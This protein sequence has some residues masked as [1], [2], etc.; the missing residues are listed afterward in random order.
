MVTEVMIT[1]TAVVMGLWC[2]NDGSGLMVV[3]TRALVT[4]VG[5]L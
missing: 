5:P 3:I 2:G 1:S 4:A